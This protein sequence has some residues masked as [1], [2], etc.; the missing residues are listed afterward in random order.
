MEDEFHCK[1]K[2]IRGLLEEHELDVLL[3]RQVGN[4]AWATCGASSYINRADSAGVAS[5][6]ITRTNRFV[7]TNNIESARLLKEEG[8][9]KQEWEFRVSP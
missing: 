9:A 3:L 5:L 8:L 6:L 2:R 1:Q 7:L 4:F